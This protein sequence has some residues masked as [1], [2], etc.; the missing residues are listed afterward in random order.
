[1]ITILLIDDSEAFYELLKAR[2]A[3]LENEVDLSWSA[4]PDQIPDKKFDVYF[5]DNRYY[6][7]DRGLE[8]VHKIKEHDK[9]ACIHVVSAHGDFPLLKGLFKSRV[10]G[11]IDKCDE[12]FTD[13]DIVV[14]Q[15]AKYKSM[16]SDFLEKINQLEGI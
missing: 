9:D 13:V 15:V 1:M 12:D 4:D 5:I 3:R 10:D 6:G 14:K 7:E 2:L 16:K 8:V 11:F